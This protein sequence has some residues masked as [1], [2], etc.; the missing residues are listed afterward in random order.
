MHPNIPQQKKTCSCKKG[1]VVNESTSGSLIPNISSP[2]SV[3]T[4]YRFP[5]L[6]LPT[7]SGQTFR[8]TQMLMGEVFY[9]NP[10]WNL[11]KYF[12]R[13][14]WHSPEQKTTSSVRLLVVWISCRNRCPFDTVCSVYSVLFMHWHTNI[15][16]N[17]W[18]C[19]VKQHLQEYMCCF[20][21]VCI[22]AICSTRTSSLKWI[23]KLLSSPKF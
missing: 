7:L 11:L 2:A 12:P 22:D 4:L 1:V 15:C 14:L 20:G 5:L 3:S 10:S 18:K 17:T 6:I 8:W 9:R 19:G 16:T 21:Q 13:C 23:L